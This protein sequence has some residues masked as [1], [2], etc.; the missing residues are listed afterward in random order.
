LSRPR[1]WATAAASPRPATPSFGQKPIDMDA[2]RLGGDE[3]LLT[4]LPVGPTGGNQ[5]QDLGLP[6]GSTPARWPPRAPSARPLPGR[7]A[8]PTV[9]G[10]GASN[11]SSRRSGRCAQPDGDIVGR[12]QRLFDSGSS[13]WAVVPCRRGLEQGERLRRGVARLRR[14]EAG[15]RCATARAMATVPSWWLK[16]DLHGSDLHVL[17]SDDRRRLLH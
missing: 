8:S 4:D 6:T 9:C 17:T 7:L 2:G 13:T 10:R 15:S 16:A 1:R 12:A 5:R 11:S 3:Q 14:G